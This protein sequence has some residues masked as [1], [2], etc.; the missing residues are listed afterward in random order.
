VPATA[1]AVLARLADGRLT[2]KQGF[3]EPSPTRARSPSEQE[4]SSCFGTALRLRT[5]VFGRM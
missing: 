1:V 4:G 3:G 5:L 2:L